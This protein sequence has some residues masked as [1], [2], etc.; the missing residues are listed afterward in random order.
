MTFSRLPALGPEGHDER[1]KE[2]ANLYK[3]SNEKDGET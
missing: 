3:A 2:H 1:D